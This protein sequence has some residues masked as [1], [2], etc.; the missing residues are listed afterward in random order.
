MEKLHKFI[1]LLLISL[2]TEA[3][4]EPWCID[5][6][7][8]IKAQYRVVIKSLASQHTYCDVHQIT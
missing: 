2:G 5:L 1:D 6:Y 7:L 3:L 4:E 8:Y